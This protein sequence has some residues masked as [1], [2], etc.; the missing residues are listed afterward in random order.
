MLKTDRWRD[1]KLLREQGHTIR[2]I[3]RI[4]GHSR[5]TVRKVL[6][7]QAPELFQIRKRSSKL[8]PFKTY[9]E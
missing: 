3:T 8:D 5:N 2:E 7:E 9:V 4:T 6:R 1:I